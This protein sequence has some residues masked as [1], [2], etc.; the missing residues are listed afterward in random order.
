MQPYCGVSSS[1]IRLI[2]NTIV[3]TE[4]PL[5]KDNLKIKQKGVVPG[6]G[7]IYME[8]RGGPW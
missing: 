5:F 3:I 8:V 6:E 2:D 7:L 1:A 4:E